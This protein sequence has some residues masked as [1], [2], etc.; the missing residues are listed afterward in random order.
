METVLATR[1]LTKRYGRR[2]VVDAVSLNV[3]KGDIYG[4]L[5]PNGAGKT[6]TLRMI[7]GLVTPTS[8]HVE[9]LGRDPSRSPRSLMGEVGSLIE[10]PAFYPHL[11]AGENLLILQHLRRHVDRR[12]IE[13]LLELVGLADV[14]RMPVD[15]FSTGMKQRLAIAL[16]LSGTPQMLVLD[17][18]TNGLDPEG[19]RE[20]RSLLRRL[21]AERGV[22]VLLSSHLL[23][24]IEQVAT[25]IGVIS[26]G[27]L[28]VEAT[29]DELRGQR[30]RCLEVV[31]SH[32]EAAQDLITRRLGAKVERT[33][34]LTLLIRGLVQ[35][36]EVNALLVRNDVAVS[37]LVEREASLETIFF[38]LTGGTVH[39]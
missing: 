29:V 24:E 18:P 34:D 5:G 39:A 35:P 6:T 13:E 16:A 28:L 15:R 21:A 10:G 3:M 20:L 2:A 19:F 30:E 9:I 8:G 27:R 17:E 22:T 38:N 1:S 36:A 26:G 32:P 23:H 11:P 31:V 4:F 14:G 12:E 33:G 37:R 25:R 7:V